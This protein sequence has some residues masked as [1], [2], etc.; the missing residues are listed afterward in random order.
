MRPE[1]FRQYVISKLTDL[2]AEL[3]L[4]YN[5]A[6]DQRRLRWVRKLRDTVVELHNDLQRGHGDEPPP[7]NIRA[8][9]TQA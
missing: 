7:N 3:M 1:E 9:P 5:F 4:Y 6:E 8:L 2:A